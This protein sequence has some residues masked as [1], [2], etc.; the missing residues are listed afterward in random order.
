MTQPHLKSLL[1]DKDMLADTLAVDIVSAEK[2]IYSGR[3]KMVIASGEAGEMGI[4]PGHT[5]LL[6]AIKPGEVRLVDL[7]GHETSFYV[8]GG[9]IEVQPHIVTILADTVMRAEE[10][11]EERALEAKEH[12]EKVLASKATDDYAAALAEL[13]K[14]I[15]QIR[16]AKKAHQHARKR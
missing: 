3:A 7:A 1:Q 10:I 16:L 5:Q 14:A 15:A 13:S 4:L 6:S 2:S 9:F 8:S 11:D 12:A